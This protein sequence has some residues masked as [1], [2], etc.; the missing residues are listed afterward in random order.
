MFFWCSRGGHIFQV[1]RVGRGWQGARHGDLIDGVVTFFSVFR[2]GR[3]WQVARHG[4]LIRGGH[5]FSV[6]RVDMVI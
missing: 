6:F 2:V 3:G 5:I 1:F 4:D